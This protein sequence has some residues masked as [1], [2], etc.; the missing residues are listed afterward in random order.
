[1]NLN[2]NTKCYI[3]RKQ[4]YQFYDNETA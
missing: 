1:M 4:C 2:L 3:G